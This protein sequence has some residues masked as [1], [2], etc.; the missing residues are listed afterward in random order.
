MQ[1]KGKTPEGSGVPD[2]L[3]EKKD[4]N[5]GQ[6]HLGDDQSEESLEYVKTLM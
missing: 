3:L 1:P 5:H 4:H 6:S 2:D